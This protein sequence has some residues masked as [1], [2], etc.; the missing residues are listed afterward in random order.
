MFSDLDDVSS[1]GY[2]SESVRE[3]VKNTY[4]A[5]GVEKLADYGGGANDRLGHVHG[6]A[7]PNLRRGPA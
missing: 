5:A 3:R 2:V 1:L 4:H 7:C 6:T